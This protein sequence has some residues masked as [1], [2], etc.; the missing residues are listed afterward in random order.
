[1]MAPAPAAPGDPKPLVWLAERSAWLAWGFALLAAALLTCHPAINGDVV[2][3]LVAS[4]LW[5]DGAELYR[6]VRDPNP[7]LIFYLNRPALALAEVTGMAQHR[8][9]FL[10]LAVALLAALGLAWRILPAARTGERLRRD[11]F[12]AAAAFAAALYPIYSAGQ[13]EHLLAIGFLP[14]LAWLARSLAESREEA[15]RLP[16]R[17]ACL[18]SA[19]AAAL[20]WLKPYFILL[21]L[22]LEAWHAWR[23]G[24]WR[25][26]LRYDV[27]A[28]GLTALLLGALLLLLHPDYI[29][30]MA[31]R[32]ALYFALPSEDLPARVPGQLVLGLLLTFGLWRRPAGGGRDLVELFLVAAPAA[33]LAAALQGKWWIYHTLPAEIF[34]GLAAAAFL[35]LL[36]TTRARPLLPPDWPRRACLALA[37]LA[38]VV[39]LGWMGLHVYRQHKLYYLD[40]ETAV[41][42]ETLA[43]AALLTRYGAGEPVVV[44]D[45]VN[46][47]A[48]YH[49]EARWGLIDGAQWIPSAINL[50]RQGGREPDAQMLAL[51]QDYLE[52]TLALFARLR[53]PVMAFYG[54]N[55]INPMSAL[56]YLQ[57]QPRFVS[58]IADYESLGRLARYEV[59]VRRD[60]LQERQ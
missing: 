30:M 42:A 25:A 37:T 50:V 19:L 38:A 57:L 40:S 28:A 45:F 36:A 11:G 48:V 41:D 21:P 44:F 13:R 8:A 3:Y 1:M 32:G 60:R 7:P 52:E 29:A 49:S 34:L 43:L 56:A 4:E 5:A 16:R 53:A 51:E 35:L 33:F 22:L 39:W 17:W 24:R 27:A 2:W 14:Y 59:F 9:L 55:A 26:L 20:L 18:A 10:L 31:D 6:E 23:L 12:V 46:A 58:L 15:P 47:V 54:G